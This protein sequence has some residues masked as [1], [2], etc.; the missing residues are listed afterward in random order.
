MDVVL[1]MT[2]YPAAWEGSNITSCLGRWTLGHK[3]HRTMDFFIIWGMW[4]SINA[5]IFYQVMPNIWRACNV[6]SEERTCVNIQSL[7]MNENKCGVE[8]FSSQY[9]ESVK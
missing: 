8:D 5:Y 3:P 1:H 9:Y 2:K 6:I 4:K 7:T